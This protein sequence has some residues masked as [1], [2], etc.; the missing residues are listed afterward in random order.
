MKYETSPAVSESIFDYFKNLPPNVFV[1]AAILPATAVTCKSKSSWYTS[2]KRNTVAAL[3]FEISIVTIPG[4]ESII[5]P[6][7]MI[8]LRLFT[9]LDLLQSIPLF[10]LYKVYNSTE[11]HTLSVSAL[12]AETTASTATSLANVLEV[13]D[14]LVAALTFHSPVNIW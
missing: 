10:S 7:P 6:S 9:S 12:T 4:D 14:L 2:S 8:S 13:A 5:I 1:Y 3:L 11:L